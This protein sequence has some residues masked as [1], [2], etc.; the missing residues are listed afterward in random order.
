M[1]HRLSLRSALCLLTLS[2]LLA[3]CGW[4]APPTPTP[5]PEP[6]V[7]RVYTVRDPTIEG[8]VEIISQGFRTRHPDV[9]IEFIYGDGSYSELQGSA[10]TGNIP[11]VV[12]A[13]DVITPALI[14]AELL[15]DL[16]EFARGD[17]SVNLEDVHPVALE[18]GRSR[19][20]PG[21]YLI[22]ASLETIQM[23]YNSS[24][25]ERSGAPLPRDDWTWDDLIAA[26]KRVQESTPGV[27][28]LSFTNSGLFDHTA[29][30]Y[31][32]PWVRGA[33]GDA[34]SADG[35]QSTLSAPQSLEGLQGY[36]DLWIR[37]KIAAQ[38]GASQD[39]CF[40]A[41]TCAAFFSFAGAARIYREQIGDR[42]AW[43]VQIV[44]AHRA[45]R[46]TGIGSYGF[47]VT[48]ASREPQLAWDF[49]KYIITPEAQRAIAAA[50]LG[51]PAL[52]SLSNDPAVVQLPPP[53]ANMRAFV[54]GREAGITPPRYP[55]AC[56]S[57]YNGPVSAAIAD[58]LDAA[59]RE[60]V[61]V[62]GAFTIADRKIQ[63]C[64][65]ANR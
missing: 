2:P 41:Q 61:S 54:V 10:A 46:F 60:T 19:V 50:Y 28:C 64:L 48:R 25:W 30:V 3:A 36:L 37:H 40:V 9:T 44:P 16:E 11:D 23:Y 34:L 17:G 22:P 12:W 5:T 38:P 35:A 1:K 6:R 53:P 47:A 33:G 51:T 14:E 39:D 24:L 52:L 45:G 57:V 4:F 13:P 56:G 20:R 63:T 62:E 31:W 43:D 27:D 26:C 29:W 58:A 59:L 18:P 55:T 42:F 65:D 32:L 15:L 8:V 7:L 21:L 49:V